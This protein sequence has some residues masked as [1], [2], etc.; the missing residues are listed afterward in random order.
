MGSFGGSLRLSLGQLG[1]FSRGLG[2]Q[3]STSIGAKIGEIFWVSAVGLCS[4]G[5]FAKAEVSCTMA[6]ARKIV[7]LA[8]TVSQV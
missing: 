3:V 6:L 1:G 7:Q 4:V 8:R 2:G 5:L